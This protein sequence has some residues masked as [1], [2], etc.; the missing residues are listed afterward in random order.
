MRALSEPVD[1]EALDEI[2]EEFGRK[3]VSSQSLAYYLER[4]VPDSALNVGKLQRPQCDPGF[5]YKTNNYE[6]HRC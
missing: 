5:R 6:Y 2:F 4:R 1:P 3:I